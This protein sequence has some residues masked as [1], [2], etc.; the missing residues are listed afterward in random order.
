M[1]LTLLFRFCSAHDTT[2]AALLSVFDAYDG[3]VPP[4]ASS[5]VLELFATAQ[6]ENRVRV[7]Y[8]NDLDNPFQDPIQL[9]C[10]ISAESPECTLAAFIDQFR[11]YVPASKAIWDSW[12]EPDAELNPTP[13]VIVFLFAPFLFIAFHVRNYFA[14]SRTEYSRPRKLSYGS[15]GGQLETGA[16]TTEDIDLSSLSS[17]GAPS[18][19]H[20]PQ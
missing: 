4:Y 12:C 7:F 11:P 16:L 18:G 19:D 6:G 10:S 2:V 14:A 1:E 13:F 3:V 20:N 15:V 17:S 5:V 9:Q 8:N